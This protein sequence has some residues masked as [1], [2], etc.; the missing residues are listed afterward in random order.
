MLARSLLAV[1]F[2]TAATATSS[3]EPVLVER[4]DLLALIDKAQDAAK[5]LDAQIAKL[6]PVAPAK[7]KGA[8]K[9]MKARLAALEGLAKAAPAPAPPAPCTT[10]TCTEAASTP[11]AMSALVARVRA[12]TFAH[13]KV[14]AITTAAASA[15]F[16]AA[17]AAELLGLL[18]FAKDRLAALGALAPCLLDLTAA[19]RGALLDHFSMSNDRAQAEALLAR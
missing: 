11:E 1:F 14:E 3:A 15:R 9:T 7:L 6:G 4:A 8:A 16:T 10:A 18:T 12:E 13:D 17:Q 19:S 5:D 2:V